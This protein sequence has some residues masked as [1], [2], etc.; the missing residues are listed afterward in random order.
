MQRQDL[1]D[2]R[3][4]TP[5]DHN[6]IFATMLRGLYY[7]DS[8]FSKIP[9]DIFMLEYHKI[10]ASLLSLPSIQVKVACLRDD[11]EVVLGYALLGSEGKV[12][13]FVYVK[14]A[15]RKIGIATMLVGDTP[16]A[17]TH[18]TTVGESILK[19]YPEVIFNPFTV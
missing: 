10:V 1:V 11:P 13:H 7:G 17:V 14:S 16:K 18:L 2:I 4:G 5:E 12:I 9:K 15:W 6:F 3:I 8:W 19:K